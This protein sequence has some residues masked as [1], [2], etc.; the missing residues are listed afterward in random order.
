[1]QHL[2]TP[3]RMSYLRGETMPVSGCLFCQLLAQDHDVEN[4]ILY[5]GAHI[6][7]ILNR[8]PYSN[9][10]LMLVPSAHVP[11]LEE[12][13]EPALAELMRL[14]QVALR[15]LRDVYQ[16]QGFNIGVNIGAA[17]GAGIPDHVHQHVLPRW[18]G[19]TNFMTTVGR[20]RI[21]PDELETTYTRLAEVLPN[22][23]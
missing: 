17:A 8:Y 6:V 2:W 9:G 16:P 7:V 22:Y 4:L 11:S 12:L 19:D 23:L 5:R 14:T 21:I 20:T 3:W 18:G 10:H 15:S 1:M 13:A